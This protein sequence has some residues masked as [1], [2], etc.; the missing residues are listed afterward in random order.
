MPLLLDPKGCSDG[1]SRRLFENYV[2]NMSAF[3][4]HDNKQIKEAALFQY[5]DHADPD[6][7]LKIRRQL[8]EIRTDNTFHAPAIFEANALSRAGTN[9]FVYVFSHRAKFLL[10]PEWTGAS[11][12]ADIFFTFGEPVVKVGLLET[13]PFFMS[14]FTDIEKGLS[15]FMMKMWANF[16]KFG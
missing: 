3:T 4:H 7:K 12:G 10:M 15:V 11:H 16:A 13:F 6:S 14:G 9:P 8:I 2:V 1:L 5:T